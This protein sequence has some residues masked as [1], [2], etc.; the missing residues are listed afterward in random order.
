MTG[1]D[2]IA[3][4]TIRA[5]DEVRSVTVFVGTPPANQTPITFAPAAGIAIALPPSAGQVLTTADR[6]M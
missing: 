3:V 2:G 5:G 1:V 6:R 4:L